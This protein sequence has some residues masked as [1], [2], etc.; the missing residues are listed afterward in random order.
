MTE[1]EWLTC[2]DPQKMLEF[3]GGKASDRKAR[4]FAVACC[5][6][7]LHLLTDARSRR[8]VEVA[9]RFADGEATDNERD[10][11]DAAANE[12]SKDAYASVA[13]AIRRGADGR[14]IFLGNYNSAEATA[15]AAA[16]CYCSTL[17]PGNLSLSTSFKGSWETFMAWVARGAASAVAQ[18]T[19]RVADSVPACDAAIT[20]AEKSEKVEQCNLLRCLFGNPIRP[21]LLASSWLTWNDGTVQKIAQAI[22][23]ERA[24]DRMSILANALE[25]AGCTKQDIRTHCRQPGEHVRG[26]WVVDLLLGK[27]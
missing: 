23:D 17:A 16:V 4:L 22:Y 13:L 2:A 10:V 9:E 6:R 15:T 8:A 25:E 11:A 27:D 18:A 12:A 21:L 3:L 26:C 5:R 24:F 14:M 1:A 7:I 19:S 20:T